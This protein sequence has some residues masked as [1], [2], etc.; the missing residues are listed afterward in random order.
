MSGHGAGVLAV[1][2]AT[3][4]GAVLPD[5]PA[6]RLRRTAQAPTGRQPRRPSRTAPWWALAPVAGTAVLV[7][8]RSVVLGAAAAFVALAAAQAANA[9]ATR[10]REVRRRGAA[11]DLVTSLA[12]ELRGG[13]EPRAAL[14][15]A[16]DP[17]FPAVA[18]MARSPAADP[19]VALLLAAGEAG[20]ELLADLAAAWRVAERTGA[21][22]AAPAARL[23]EAAR[24][25]TAVRRELEAQLAGPRAT[26]GLLSLLP[27]A[28]VLLGT[29]L[30]ADPAGFLLGSAGGRPCLLIGALLVAAG[31][32]WTEAIVAAAEPQ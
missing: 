18:A 26:A 25:A 28:G 5:D 22:L 23:G 19:A 11:L 20:H 8:T 10:R 3:A 24:A 4:A 14:L 21:G 17:V 30:G 12:A 32:G 13:A 29:A 7:L 15:T 9:R 16:S 2:L 1:A 6:A 27:G 31:V